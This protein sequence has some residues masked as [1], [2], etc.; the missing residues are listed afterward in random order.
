MRRRIEDGSRHLCRSIANQTV[1]NVKIKYGDDASDTTH[2][3]LFAA[4]HGTLAAAQL[5][6]LGPRSVAGRMAR[7]AGIQMV[8]ELHCSSRKGSQL[9]QEEVPTLKMKMFRF[10]LSWMDPKEV[11]KD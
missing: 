8:T 5:Y 9:D 3:A 11:S 7:K 2:H 4:G 6:D 10:Y 1:Q